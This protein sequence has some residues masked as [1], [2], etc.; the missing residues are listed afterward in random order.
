[1]K[2]QKSF[3][4]DENLIEELEKLAVAKNMKLTASLEYV[5]YSYFASLKNN[6]DYSKKAFSL[7]IDK[8]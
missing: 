2:I 1:M 5:L 8:L 4:I 3:K 6:I 7:I